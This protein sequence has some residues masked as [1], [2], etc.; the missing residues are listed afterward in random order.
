M[1]AFEYKAL[2]AKG[3]HKKGVIEGDNARQVRQRLKEQSLVPM[4][5][6]ETQVKAAR[7]RSQG[8]AFKRGIST[9]DLALITR[10]RLSSIRYATGRVFTRGCRAVGKTADSHHVGGG[11]R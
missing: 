1:A 11:A 5:V 3:R 10:M 6:V 9:P 2:D 7:S 8:F 4:E